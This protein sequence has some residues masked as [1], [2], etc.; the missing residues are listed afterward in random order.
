MSNQIVRVGSVSYINARPL[1][2]GFEQ[3]MM[4]HEVELV[5]DYPAAIADKLIKGEID[6]GLVPVAIIPKLAYHQ[7]ISDFGIACDGEVASVCLFSDQ[8]IERISGILLDYQ[9][10]SSVALLKVLLKEHWKI[11]PQLIDSAPGYEMDI[12]GTKGG[13]VI[14]DRALELRGKHPYMYDLG[15]AWK[16]MTGLPFVFAAWISNRPLPVDF[17]RKFNDSTSLGLSQLNTV[18]AENPYPFFNLQE[19]YTRF[20]K[21]RLDTRMHEAIALFLNK[22]GS[23]S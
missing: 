7:V 23:S 5:R 19:Y 9:S 3:G 12:Q 1:L 11:A 4:S 13:L 22:L 10:R 15:Q 6:V 16:E 14:G 17:C 2:Y 8:P 18:I 20:I 21:F